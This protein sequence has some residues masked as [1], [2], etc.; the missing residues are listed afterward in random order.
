MK[1]IAYNAMVLKE[2]YSGVE[3]T[4]HQLAAALAEFGTLVTEIYLP[5]NHRP[6]QKS[7]HITLHHSTAGT[8]SRLIR[9]LWEQLVLPLKLTR[10]NAGLLHAP[11]YVAP[12]AAPCPVVL[13]V[14]DLHAMTHPQFCTASNRLHYS[15][16]IPP[17][18]RKAAA[19]I[20]FSEYT[21]RTI[22]KRF[23]EAAEKI[24]VIPP[25]IS[26]L[27]KYH[28][29]SVDSERVRQRYQLP[30]SFLLFVGDLTERKN[31][32]G[33]IS[34][35]KL[36][37]AKKPDLHLLLAGAINSSGGAALDNHIRQHDLAQRVSRIGYV[38]THELPHL[39]SMAQAFVFPSHDEG[40]GVPPLEAMACGCPVVCSGGAPVEICGGAAVSCDAQE[41]SSIAAAIALLLDQPQFRQEKIAAGY[42]RAAEF[43][44][45]RAAL[46]TEALY[47]TVLAGTEG[48]RG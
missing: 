40:F 29:Q 19:V 46:K 7:P 2:P 12:M 45:Q 8:R 38:E 4:V 36:V 28:P 14:H 23:P 9:I 44:W 6:I 21:K 3:V 17:S 39:Y 13:T 20:A 34:A 11:A 22:Q 18:I 48:V 1:R 37:Q 47:R 32:R 30:T 33:V 15:L 31:I 26:P 35:F 16:M 43:T 41:H 42:K 5:K 27:F 24:T 10:N 25:G